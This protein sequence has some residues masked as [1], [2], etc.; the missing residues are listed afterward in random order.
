MNVSHPMS[1]VI[2]SSEG[3]VLTVLV[4]ADGGL[5][6]RAIAELTNETISHV[7]AAKVLKRLSLA[8]IVVEESR[9]PALIFRLNHQHVAANAIVLLAS[10]R[11]ALLQRIRD[12]IDLSAIS[13]EAVWVFGSF[14]RGDGGPGSDIDLLVMRPASTGDDDQMWN[15][16]LAELAASVHQWSG[17]PCNLVE[18]TLDEFNGLISAGEQLPSDLAR[19]GIRV[20]GI[21]IPRV[22]IRKAQS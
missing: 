2:P 3:L 10:L 11:S 19:E 22:A 9:P 1:D 14:A 16:Q 5:S 6:A 17:N 4:G 21:D 20:A 13:P 15:Q 8:G 7:Q 18:Y 12:W